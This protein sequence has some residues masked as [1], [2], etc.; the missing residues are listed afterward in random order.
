MVQQ[1]TR[2]KV[3]DNTGAKELLCIRVLGGSVRRYAAVGD[4]IVATVKDATPGGVVKKGDTVRVI[5]GV[6][7]GK[8]GKVLEVKGSKVKVEGINKVKMHIKP[9]QSNPQGGI[10]EEEAFFDVSNVMY[11]VNGE[12]TRIGFKVED[13]NKVRYAKKTGAVID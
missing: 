13:N 6:D 10:V 5:A 11:V 1:E 9:N 2:L 3:A 4:I 12:V 7:K 8:E